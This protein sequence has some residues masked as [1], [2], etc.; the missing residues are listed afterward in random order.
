MAESA[1]VSLDTKKEKGHFDVETLKEYE[2]LTELLSQVPKKVQRG[3]QTQ[4]ETLEISCFDANQDFIALGSNIGIVFLY[5]R[6]KHTIE[7]LRSD[8]KNAHVSCV[9]LHSG[10][11]H[12]VAIGYLSGEIYLFQLPS[13]LIGHSKQL[14]RFVVCDLHSSPIRCLAWSTNGMK[15][16]SG[17]TKGCVGCMEVDFYEGQCK[18]SILL[19]EN[20]TEIVQLDSAHKSLLISTRHRCIICRMGNKDQLIQ[21]GSKDRKIIDDFGAVFIPAMCKPEDA[22]LYCSRPGFRIWKASIDGTVNNTFM[23]KDLLSQPHHQIPVSAFVV[24]SIEKGVPSTQFGPLRFFHGNYLVTWNQSCLYVLSPE[25]STVIGSQK[26]IGQIKSVVTT[27][28]EIFVLR[29]NTNRDFIRISTEP[30][31]ATGSR[32][33]RELHDEKE[34]RES[35]TLRAEKDEKG[36]SKN[37]STESLNEKTKEKKSSPLKF[38][39][40][41]LVEKMKKI[42]KPNEIKEKIQEKINK[43]TQGESRSSKY[44]QPYVFETVGNSNEENQTVTATDLPPVIKLDSPDLMSIEVAIDAIK[45]DMKY[46][47]KPSVEQFA[48][49]VDS[50]NREHETEVSVDRSAHKTASGAHSALRKLQDE[51]LE[52]EN[53][54]TVLSR[55]S[56][57]EDSIELTR[58]AEVNREKSDHLGDE[59]VRGSFPLETYNVVV[60]GEEGIVF[61]RKIKAKGKKKKKAQK[62]SKSNLNLEVDQDSVSVSSFTSNTSESIEAPVHLVV[63]DTVKDTEANLQHTEPAQDLSNI[64]VKMPEI[65]SIDKDLSKEPMAVTVETTNSDIDIKMA[66]MCSTDKDLSKE[67]TESAIVNDGIVKDDVLSGDNE[68]ISTIGPDAVIQMNDKSVAAT[69]NS[70]KETD[71]L[72]LIKHDVSTKVSSKQDESEIQ[73]NSDTEVKTVKHEFCDETTKKSLEEFK[74]EPSPQISVDGYDVMSV[75]SSAAEADTV[76]GLDKEIARLNS[77]LSEDPECSILEVESSPKSGPQSLSSSAQARKEIESILLKQT[78]QRYKDLEEEITRNFGQQNEYKETDLDKQLKELDFQA[79]SSSNLEKVKS[80]LFSPDSSP[81]IYTLYKTPSISHDDFYSEYSPKSL[82]SESS[83]SSFNLPTERK[84]SDSKTDV[85]HISDIPENSAGEKSVNMWTEISAQ[86]NLLSLC[87]SSSHVWYTDRSANVWYSAL[88]GPGLTWRKA[89]GY[90]YQISVSQLGNIVWRL[91]KGVAYAGTKITSKSPEG[92]KWVQ[93]VQGDVAYIG[94]DETCAWYIKT[95]YDVMIQKSLSKERP[96]YTAQQVD[97]SF[98]LKQIECLSGVVWALTEE[99]QWIYRDGV[100]EKCPEGTNWKKGV[101]GTDDRLFSCLSLGDGNIGWAIDVLGNMWFICGVTKETPRGNGIWWQVPFTGEYLMRDATTM[102]MLKAFTK[103]LDP[104]NLAY[105]LSHQRGGLVCGRSGVWFCPE[106]KHLLHVCR[107]SIEGHYWAESQPEGLPATLVWKLVEA[108]N[109]KSD[110]G[111]LW[112]QQESGD[113]F[114]YTQDRQNCGSVQSPIP[115][116]VFVCISACPDAVW[117]LLNTGEIYIRTGIGPLYPQGGGWFKLDL[118]QID[119]TYFVHLSCGNTNVWAVDNEGGT[120]HRIGVKAPKADGLNAAWL[121]VD[122]GGTVFTQIFAGPQDWMVWAVDN[123][124]QVYVRSK[125]TINMPIGREWVHV[126]GTLASQLTL[127]DNNVWALSP[128]G[129]LFCR[130]GVTEENVTGDYWK[131]FPG[132]FVY[133]SVSPSNQLWGI[134]KEGQLFRRHLKYIIKDTGLDSDHVAPGRGSRVGSDVG[135][136]ELV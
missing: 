34:K 33:L 36:S 76:S 62:D 119:T 26:Y 125:I 18:S 113:V 120:Y 23:F 25:S 58:S 2:P 71:H 117:V 49:L 67:S 84:T 53:S 66:E 1:G 40:E 46:K 17:D 27:G 52:E 16:Y 77:F 129:E 48:A 9:G 124:R 57:A 70:L 80:P 31:P 128:T 61:S 105:I 127:S 74:A 59:V 116:S 44:N 133:I 93:A 54:D 123:K 45:I 42:P 69:D 39:Q 91:Y 97:C 3:L 110:T 134:N 100:R 37:S 102:D 28:K 79:S 78:S 107:G 111:L 19:I 6:S 85:V 114:T 73:Q 132:I 5:D 15:I 35:Q 126:P 24:T 50:D 55:K 41:N 68:E 135:D 99:F 56:F 90:A 106:Y 22:Q 63:Q 112:V 47:N 32:I 13:M 104:Q 51:H 109:M 82:E 38:L 103:K 75:K 95:N 14:E 94:V 118:T 10:L 130:Y 122:N 12:V 98:K 60:P 83:A 115:G 131:K 4:I 7:R 20:E 136:W 101:S 121:P 108:R 87:A 65:S 72:S 89:S 43:D 8:D 81:S 96:C 21:V 88:T 11:D 92:L 86:G 64:D 30:L 29:R